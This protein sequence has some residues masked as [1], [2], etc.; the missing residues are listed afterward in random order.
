[1]ENQVQCPE[2]KSYKTESFKFGAI[3]F[4]LG[5]IMVAVIGFYFFPNYYIIAICFLVLGILCLINGF[6]KNSDFTCKACN[7]KFKNTKKSNQHP[8]NP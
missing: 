1:M 8:A 5:C 3:K 7:Y 2:C 6:M 4:G